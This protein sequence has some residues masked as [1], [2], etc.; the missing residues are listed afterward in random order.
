METI[1]YDKTKKMATITTEV[2]VQK[3]KE[4]LTLDKSLFE[5]EIARC[6]GEITKYQAELEKIKTMLKALTN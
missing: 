5:E 1:T 6:R 2:V 3:T 4:Q